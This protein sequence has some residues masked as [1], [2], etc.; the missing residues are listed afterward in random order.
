MRAVLRLVF[1][2]LFALLHTPL[3]APLV[4]KMKADELK[5]MIRVTRK[6]RFHTPHCLCPV[7]ALPCTS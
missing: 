2:W 1:D 6:V 4:A 5:N 7:I 3:T